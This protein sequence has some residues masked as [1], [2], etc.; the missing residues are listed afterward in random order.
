MC[1]QPTARRSIGQLLV[2]IGAS[3]GIPITRQGTVRDTYRN[4]GPLFAISM[5]IWVAKS[6]G[7]GRSCLTDN[8]LRGISP[9]KMDLTTPPKL[10][11]LPSRKARRDC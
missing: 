11:T 5:P 6:V 7:M 2:A 1:L 4:G 3:A 9:D 10:R 8:E